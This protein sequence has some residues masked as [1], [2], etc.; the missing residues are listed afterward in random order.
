MTTPTRTPFPNATVTGLPRIGPRRELKRALEALWAGTIDESE[1]AEAAHSLR[2][3]SYDRQR[4]LG[5][6]ADYAI[7]GDFSAYDQVLD[8]AL[9]AGLV[10]E[11][12]TGTDLREYFALARGTADRAPLEMTKWFDTNY[13]YLVPEVADD[14][15]FTARPQRILELV[16]EARQAGHTIRPVLLGPVTL[17]ALSKPAEGATRQPLDRLDELVDTYAELLTALHTA[18]VEWVQIDE[19]ILVTDLDEISDEE[20]AQRAG[21]AHARLLATADRPQ[22]LI[23]TPYGSLR[24]GLDALLG[25]GPEALGVDLSAATRT[26]DPDW[27][28]R[29][30]AAD[31]G[32]TRLVAG[33]I[34]GRNIWAADLE[35]ELAVLTSLQGGGRD[36][37]VST[38]TSLLHVPYTVSAEKRL[39]VDVAGWLSFAEE[40]VTEVE[41]LAAALDAHGEGA[42]DPV[43][44][45]EAA[46]SRSARA[47]RTRAESDRVVDEHVRARVAAIG[48]RRTRVGSVEERRRAQE[49]LGLPLLPTTTIGSFP[50]TPEVR[51]ARAALRGGRISEDEYTETMRAEIAQVVKLQEELGF[52][53]IVHGEPER[54]DMVQYFAEH[55]A[56]FAVTD[57]GWVQSYGS[58]CTRP[59]ILFGD[60][61]RPEPITVP[62]STYAASLTDKPVKG[63]LT[64]PVTILS[65]SF[66]RDDVP[67]STVAEQI[68]LAL[69]DEV[70]ELESAGVRIIQIDEPALRELLPLRADNRADYIAW[71]VDAFRLSSIS[72]DPGT[73]IH[74]HLCYSEFGQVIAA[75]DA[76]DADV[77]S[78]EAARSRMELL[79]SLDPEEF[80]RSVGPGVYDIHSPRVPTVDELTGLLEAAITHV[81]RESLWVNPDCGLKTR[82]YEE[83][84]PA[85]ANLVEARDAVRAKLTV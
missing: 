18:G 62:W 3:S 68:G 8:A 34:D 28:D 31:F 65:W 52:D 71:A 50:Q 45:R 54:N 58:R 13:H 64:G 78:I 5:L 17:L 38:S 37:S 49:S 7:P 56:G 66:V 1:Y 79:A 40:K 2:L 25:A 19:P 47:V 14:R 81:P 48:E 72:V 55:L 24:A 63:M 70:A 44:A 67:L 12:P 23:T 75:I 82:K 57:H 51:Q 85:L 73:Q 39:P 15:T 20:L 30:K 77:T 33:V 84:R 6:V 83:V 69:S 27:L 4:D 11:D 74:T 76:L 9:T 32:D 80:D 43:N 21:Q 59:P 42:A 16:D 41:A 10:G 46:F 29:L 35:A 36:V 22:V 60:V 26:I 53:V 61:H